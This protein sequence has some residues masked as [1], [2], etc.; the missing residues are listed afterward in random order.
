MKPD[1]A[2]G[3]KLTSNGGKSAQEKGADYGKEA[4]TRAPTDSSKLKRFL[5]DQT[6]RFS[7]QRLGRHHTPEAY[8]P[9]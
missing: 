8:N 5:F 9:I 7:G 6:G 4:S 3:E 1:E 2:T